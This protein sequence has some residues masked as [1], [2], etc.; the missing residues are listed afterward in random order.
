MKRAFCAMALTA[1]AAGAGAQDLMAAWRGAQARD[2]AY[3]AAQRSVQ[4]AHA[5][6]QQKLARERLRLAEQEL[7]LR[8]ARAYFEHL[9]AR[10]AAEQALAQ[11][12]LMA[13]QLR[14]AQRAGE[15]TVAAQAALGEAQQRFD[16]ARAARRDAL[17]E[18]E[19]SRGE[20][21]RLAGRLPGPPEVLRGDVAL[22][23]PDP[24]NEAY[25]TTLASE[26]NPRVRIQ[27]ATLEAAA[28]EVSH[29]RD[30]SGPNVDITTSRSR[31]FNDT[32][33]ATSAEHSAR[34]R[35]RQ[36]G[37]ILT[38]PLEDTPP[39]ARIREAVLAQEKAEADLAVTRGLAAGPARQAFG[40]LM[41]ALARS[42]ALAA[43]LRTGRGVLEAAQSS[44]RAGL[45]LPA[46][47]LAGVQQFYATERD[48][49]RARV[50]G[51]MHGLALKAAAGRLDEGELARV[52]E[53]LADAP[54]AT[55][56]RE[57]AALR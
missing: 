18:V 53:M 42:E 12:G 43:T 17:K 4:L 26:E 16:A 31:L 5:P 48:W 56:L 38:M 22:W 19:R 21:E 15:A 1:C 40:N 39:E 37:L 28:E 32:G 50:E 51:V 36:L 24:A 44:L 11:L 23:R 20:L 27:Q 57:D 14:S 10:Q 29:R 25:W 34:A 45:R 55:A 13:Q 49:L 8:V 30:G 54:P 46:D 2:P 9:V 6:L 41:Q 35:S 3:A 47:L 52:N 7:A 33:P